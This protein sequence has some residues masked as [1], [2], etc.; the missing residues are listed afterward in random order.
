MRREEVEAVGVAG[1]E[2]AGRLVLSLLDEVVQLRARV[3]EFERRVGQNSGNSDLPPSSDLPK[4]RAERRRAARE[5]YKRSMR[6]SGGQPGHQGKTRELVAPER[7]DDRVA[8]LPDA[9]DCGHV[10]DGSEQPVGDPVVHQQYELP[11]IVPLVVE[12]ARVRLLCPACQ[13]ATLAN[14]S[15]GALSGF[16]PRVDAHIAILAGVF[17]LSRDQVREI[18]VEV[19]GIPASKGSVDNAI[20]RMSAILADPWAELR[21][22]IG[23]AQAVHWTRRPGVE[24]HVRWRPRGWSATRSVVMGTR[25]RGGRRQDGGDPDHLGL[26]R[27]NLDAAR[28]GSP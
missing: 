4:S 24:R 1:G 28:R 21:D 5:A 19:F 13:K 8:H 9:C 6:K 20:M 2:P 3:E 27:R 17:R 22:A 18:V 25:P 10:F 14:L 12:H 7:L 23:R 15:A 26:P 11:V 16:G